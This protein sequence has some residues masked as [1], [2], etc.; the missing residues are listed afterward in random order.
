MSYLAQLKG[1]VGT[2]AASAAGGASG[3]L[4]AVAGPA[5][6]DIAMSRPAAISYMSKNKPAVA[7]AAGAVASK[8]TEI[9]RS[10]TASQGEEK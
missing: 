2:V 6:A 9:A 1:L 3:G 8:A 7:P 5:A 10:K 4:G